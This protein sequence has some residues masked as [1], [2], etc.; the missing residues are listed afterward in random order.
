M[1]KHTSKTKNGV[2]S[3]KSRTVEPCNLNQALLVNRDKYTSLFSKQLDF[4]D[5]CLSVTSRPFNC[6]QMKNILEPGFMESLKEEIQ[7]LELKEKNNDLYK[8]HQSGE[9]NKVKLPALQGF[10]NM[11]LEQ[12]KPIISKVLLIRFIIL[13]F[14]NFDL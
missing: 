10:R 4:E 8:F 5:S 11:L 2:S 1:P 3:K 7:G 13:Y 9:L 14:Q 12:L 6:C